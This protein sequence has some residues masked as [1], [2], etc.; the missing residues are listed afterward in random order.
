MRLILTYISILVYTLTVTGQSTT[1][2]YEASAQDERQFL[3]YLVFDYLPSV[4]LIYDRGE[5]VRRVNDQESLKMAL[6]RYIYKSGSNDLGKY[7][8]TNGIRGKDSINIMNRYLNPPYWRAR[9][10]LPDSVLVNMDTLN[11]YDSV[12]HFHDQIIYKMK[13]TPENRRAY[14]VN[15]IHLLPDSLQNFIR[16]H[17]AKAGQAYTEYANRCMDAAYITKPFFLDNGHRCFMSIRF[18]LMDLHNVLTV[19]FKKVAEQWSVERIL[20]DKKMIYEH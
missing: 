7:L 4:K 15:A 10:V 9:D 1:I 12:N 3:Q 8:A 6:V 14:N 5:K 16:F 17:R 11:Y 19:V 13:M 20:Y 2:G 18:F